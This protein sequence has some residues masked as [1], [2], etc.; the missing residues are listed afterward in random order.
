MPLTSFPA[1]LFNIMLDFQGQ[2][3]L[4]QGSSTTTDFNVAFGSWIGGLLAII[5]TISLLILLGMLIL[6]AIQWITSGGDSGKLQSSRDRMLHAIIG[7]L[8][9][10]SVLAVFIFVQYL[11]GV[12]IISFGSTPTAQEN[13]ENAV[14]TGAESTR[15]WLIP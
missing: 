4:I 8:I 5:M 7:I 10:S 2:G 15:N 13:A 11:L 3:D 9:L 12:E 14:T 1:S 6:G